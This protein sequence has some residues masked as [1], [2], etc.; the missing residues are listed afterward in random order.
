MQ[1]PGMV[2]KAI[3]PAQ[4]GVV[5]LLILLVIDK[6]AFWFY[7]MSANKNGGKHPCKDD[8]RL[9]AAFEVAK[10]TEPAHLELARGINKLVTEATKQTEL[11]RSIAKNGGGT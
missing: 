9:L 4:L 2:T 1:D 8:P 3:D 5:G 7:K 10:R 6:V 11:L